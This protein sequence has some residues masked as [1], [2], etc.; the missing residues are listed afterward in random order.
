MW[1]EFTIS[2]SV[3]LVI[4]FLSNDRHQLFGVTQ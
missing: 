4:H 1:Y 3:F 2:R